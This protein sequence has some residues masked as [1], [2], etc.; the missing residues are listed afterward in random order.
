MKRIYSK[1]WPD[2]ELIDAGDNKKLERWG[3][4]ITIRPDRNAYFKPVL[5]INEWNQRAHYE[6]IELSANGGAWSSLKKNFPISNDHEVPNW[7]ISFNKCVFN[8]RLTKFKHLGIFPEQQ[9]NWEFISNHLS[10]NSKFLNLFAYTGGASLIANSKN[11]EVYHCDSV[12]QIITWAK[13]NMESSKQKG[14]HWVLD[15]ALKFAKKEV[16]RGKKYDGII[17]DPPAFGIGIN[18]ERWKIETKF[19]ELVEIASE[20]LSKKG[21]LIINTYSPKL[22][23]ELIRNTV[24]THFSSKNID[25]KK[26]SL[27][28]TTGKILEY[29]ELTRVY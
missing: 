9:I 6:F 7:Q 12:K 20:L 15:D 3:T 13:N 10:N 17:M 18:K 25:I 2:Y 14:I 27:K 23:E 22:K 16:K 8:L 24:Q 19:P 29:G 26:L 1:H 28:T 4:I 5:S 21:F 11:S